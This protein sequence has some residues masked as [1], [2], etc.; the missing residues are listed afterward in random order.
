[1]PYIEFKTNIDLT[2]NDILTLKAKTA[3]DLAASFP[4]KTENWLMLNFETNRTMFFAG[5]ASPC[6][7]A[8]VDLFGNQKNEYYDKF[9]ST[10]TETLEKATKIPA[11]RIYIKYTEY[12]H[13]GWNGGNF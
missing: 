11:N 12:S 3:D 2:E 9:T 4:G 8:N 13:W 1:M 6:I 5:D 10:L 7:I